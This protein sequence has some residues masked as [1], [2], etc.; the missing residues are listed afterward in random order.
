MF[1]NSDISDSEIGAKHVKC[2]TT[3]EI[4]DGG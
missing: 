2:A 1:F 3:N 4:E